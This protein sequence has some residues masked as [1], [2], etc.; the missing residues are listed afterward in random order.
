MD[1]VSTGWATWDGIGDSG[2]GHLSTRG[3]ALDGAPYTPESRRGAERGTA[4]EELI[5]AAHAGC[6]AMELS[7]KLA[8]RGCPDGEFKAVARVTLREVP[9]NGRDGGDRGDEGDRYEIVRSEIEASGSV[10]GLED[11][12]L[13]TLAREALTDC[14]V[15]RL[16]NCEIALVTRFGEGPWRG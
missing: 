13:E 14:P 5:A 9:G 11:D 16:L 15:S 3:D 10:E 2:V 4:P 8:R 1:I 12:A 6:F 7:Y